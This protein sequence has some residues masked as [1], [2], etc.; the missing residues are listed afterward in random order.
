MLPVENCASTKNWLPQ[1]KILCVCKT[2]R[3]QLRG[4]LYSLITREVKFFLNVVIR[5]Q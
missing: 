3:K 1:Y 4:I 5:Q 2:A